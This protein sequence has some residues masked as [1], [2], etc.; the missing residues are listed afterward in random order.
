MADWDQD[1]IPDLVVIKTSRTGSGTTEVHVLSG[2]SGF[3]TFTL[4]SPSALEELSSPHEVYLADWNRDG[5]PDLVVVLKGATGSGMTE[6]HVVS[7]AVSN[8]GN[9]RDFLVHAATPFP[10]AGDQL[11]IIPVGN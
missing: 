7:G 5:V 8:G 2:A 10:W 1:G 6:V 3:Q 4:H 9:F 11:Q